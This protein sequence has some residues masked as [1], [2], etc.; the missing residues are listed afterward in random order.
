MDDTLA[1]QPATG[2]KPPETQMAAAT[3]LAADTQGSG[4]RDGNDPSDEQREFEEQKVAGKEFGIGFDG[5][6]YRY[7]AHR[8]DRFSDALTYARLAHAKPNHP[9]KTGAAAEWLDRKGPTDDEMRTMDELAIS[10]DGKQYRYEGHRYER[11]NDAFNYA[12][13]NRR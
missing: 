2:H 3:G 12:R 7:L 11:V 5:R 9:D 10:F 4:L 1:G 13:L 8:Y 6:Q